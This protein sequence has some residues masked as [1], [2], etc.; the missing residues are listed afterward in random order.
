MNNEL[1]NSIFKELGYL[2]NKKG[3]VSVT[4]IMKIKTAQ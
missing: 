4:K 2:Y 3:Y 1:K